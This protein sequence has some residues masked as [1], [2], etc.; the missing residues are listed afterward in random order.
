MAITD[1]RPKIGARIEH[2]FDRD[3]EAREIGRIDLGQADIDGVA[4]SDIATDDRCAFSDGAGTNARPL[5]DVDLEGV[6]AT[7]RH[8]ERH[9]RFG[10]DFRRAL[11]RQ[12]GNGGDRVDH[13]CVTVWYRVSSA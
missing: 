12:R 11:L 13:C 1:A 2:L 3:P 6:A 5:V 7:L 8:D 4:S 9:N 10:R